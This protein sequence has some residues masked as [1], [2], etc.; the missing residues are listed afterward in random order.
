MIISKTP[1]RISFVG[2]GS[3]NLMSQKNFEGKVISVTIDKFVYLCVNKK[4]DNDIRFSYSLTEN[5]N[6]SDKL[7]HPIARNVLQ[8][9]RI[10]NGLEI[11]SIADIPSSGSGLGSSSAFLVGL[12]NC[13]NFYK[14]KNMSKKNIAKLACHIELIKMRQPIGMQ[15]QYSAAYGGF[16]TMFFKN[17]KVVVN[18]LE[19]NTKR[20][21]KFKE[22][23][24]LL[25]TNKTRDANTILRS[26]KSNKNIKSLK[27]I[28]NLVDIFKY[29]LCHGDINNLGKIL[30]ENW[31]K[32]KELSKNISN[33]Y[34]DS[35]YSYAINQGA[36]GG[37]LLGAGGGGFFLFFVKN[38]FKKI[39]LNKMKKFDIVDF[40]F[41]N[42]GTQIIYND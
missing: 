27:E 37:K 26:V 3:D 24:V 15:D 25:S 29:E 32:K 30:H 28:V 18:K 11:S 10:S 6:V 23:L 39:F 19:L 1:L 41:Y 5:V 16:N 4:F 12:I 31:I 40:N 36:L 2:G 34:L 14:K 35:I 22:S 9:F 42:S 7:E 20:L 21:K 13:L 17:N 33:D 38:N 8:Y